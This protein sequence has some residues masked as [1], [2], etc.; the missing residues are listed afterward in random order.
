VRQAGGHHR[1]SGPLDD[2][3]RIADSYSNGQQAIEE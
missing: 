1:Y 3:R 2:R